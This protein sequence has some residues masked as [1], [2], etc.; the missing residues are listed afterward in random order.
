[1]EPRMCV[2]VCRGCYFMIMLSLLCTPTNEGSENE[3]RGKGE[4]D[5][6]APVWVRVS[7]SSNH[8]RRTLSVTWSFCFSQLA[9]R[10]DRMVIFI[11]IIALNL[12]ADL[13]KGS[14]TQ[15]NSSMSS[16]IKTSAM[17]LAKDNKSRRTLYNACGRGG[18]GGNQGLYF[19]MFVFKLR[20]KQCCCEYTLWSLT[21]CKD[22]SVRWGWACG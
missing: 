20:S 16:R 19:S 5:S 2:C 21:V 8:R 9:L 17:P 6:C 10:A 14:G 7:S 22:K 11:V 4:K 1:M 12:P 15:Q 18:G 13:W 3:M